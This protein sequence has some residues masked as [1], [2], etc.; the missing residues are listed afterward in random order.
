MVCIV[1]VVVVVVVVSVFLESML[2]NHDAW[3]H[4]ND[5]FD[6]WELLAFDLYCFVPHLGFLLGAFV[7]V[8]VIIAESFNEEVLHIDVG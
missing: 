2:A 6:V 5:F 1:V 4:L 8:G 3:V 7:F